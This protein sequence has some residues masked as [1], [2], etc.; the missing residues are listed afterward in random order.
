MSSPA[1]VVIV[2]IDASEGSKAALPVAR[3]WAALEDASLHI[4]HV[5]GAEAPNAVPARL[6][7]DP[8]DTEHAVVHPR[9]GDP[10][11]AILGLAYEYAEATIVMA[12]RTIAADLAAT[13]HT[14]E[15]VISEAHCPLVF[16]P[17]SRGQ[18]PWHP[19]KV[20][21]PH[22]GS[23]STTFALGR[24]ARL[25]RA[26]GSRLFV[27]HVATPEGEHRKE[28]GVLTAP[29]YVDQAQHEWP[30]WTEE[31]LMRLARGCPVDPA[32]ITMN[33]ARGE[34][35][36][37]VLRFAE[38]H[39]IDLIVVTWYGGLDE[40]RAAVFKHV[41]SATPCPIAVLRRDASE[42]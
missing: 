19:H 29:R 37:A 15:R 9:T 31:F 23:P 20:L 26:A 22:D 10:A 2:P 11:V 40:R 33:V 12:P 39:A 14:A 4:V 38:E 24:I 13:P 16:V 5:G 32:A 27:V 25:V 34:A 8:S 28:T 30:A 17:R 35:A 18:R 3:T 7:L 36:D 6:S 1:R 41:L 42:R 21:I